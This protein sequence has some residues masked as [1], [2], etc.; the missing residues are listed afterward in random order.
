M[1]IPLWLKDSPQMKLIQDLA[2]DG[3]PGG[4]VCEPGAALQ[5]ALCCAG[6]RCV[7]ARKLPMART[8]EA[9]PILDQG[10]FGTCVSNACATLLRYVLRKAG[11]ADYQP[12]RMFLFWH[13]TKGLRNC[14]GSGMRANMDVLRLLGV[15]PESAWPYVK[16]ACKKAPPKKV[17]DA[18][19][20]ASAPWRS[21]IAYAIVRME[22]VATAIINGHPVAMGIK[23][24]RGFTKA[25]GAIPSPAVPDPAGTGTHEMLAIGVDVKRGTVTFQNSWGLGFGKRG[26]VTMPLAYVLNPANSD[27]G[28]YYTMM[29]VGK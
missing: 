12:S 26:F 3:R 16:S 14:Q 21:R 23:L 2:D 8:I 9:A 6:S 19:L 24:P 18:A 29:I 13:A 15:P 7:P 28:P 27:G 4:L 17:M 22:D 11:F 20:R 5:G 10:S 25:G 1:D